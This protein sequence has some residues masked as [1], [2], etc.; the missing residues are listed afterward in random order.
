MTINNLDIEIETR[1]LVTGSYIEAITDFCQEKGIEE[2]NIVDLLNPILLEK[3]KV[4]FY[5]KNYFPK[6]KIKNSLED[7]I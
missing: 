1:A 3:V 7:F 4:E 6:K 2:E 5:K